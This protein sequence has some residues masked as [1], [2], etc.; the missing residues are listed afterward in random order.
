MNPWLVEAYS[1]DVQGQADLSQRSQ[2]DRGEIPTHQQGYIKAQEPE[3]TFTS[4][5]QLQPV[6]YCSLSS[7]MS[8][9]CSTRNYSSRSGGRCAVPVTAV[10]TTSG[11]D[12]D[13]LSGIYLP[14]SFQ[15][16]SWLL[17]HCEETCC[18]PTACQPT[19]FSP[20]SCAPSPGQV[21]YSRQTTCVSNPCSTSYNRPITFVSS[22]CQSSG[23]ISNPCQPMGG[24]STV[25]RPMGGA[26]SG[27]QSMGGV[28]SVCRPVMA[29]GLVLLGVNKNQA[30]QNMTLKPG[31]IP[32]GSSVATPQQGYPCYGTNFHRTFRATPLN[33]VV[34]LGSPL[35]YGCGC[36]GY[37]SLG[38]SF[39]GSNFGN[40]G[41][42]YGGSF[43]R[44]WGSG[45]GF[46]YS[47]Y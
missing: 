19:C 7:T 45:S 17:E 43:Y 14:S 41:C 31:I 26:T 32:H 42:G 24:I 5:S 13:G 29:P 38:Y 28:S 11:Q 9:N 34:P 27:C 25:C 30:W 33:C 2:E 47:T 39:G 22:G 18:E 16:G 35:N 8:Y 4:R 20:S 46:G 44:P 15:T 12:A 6:T 10:A 1:R 3:V 36:N 37:G 40:L 21:T 23:G